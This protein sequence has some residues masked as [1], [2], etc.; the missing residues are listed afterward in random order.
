MSEARTIFRNTSF[1]AAS[2]VVERLATLALIFVVARALGAS[3]LGVYAAA[4]AFYGLFTVAGD[5]GASNLMVREIARDRSVAAKYL[6][7]LGAAGI[8]LAALATAGAWLVIP[9]VGLE[10]DL[11][12]G[13]LIVTLATIPG[14]LRI[15]QE[16]VFV[17]YQRLEFQAGVT[18]VVSL[19]TV[20][21]TITLI[22]LGYGV[23][24][25]IVAFVVVRWAMVFVYAALLQRFI[26]SLR[27]RWSFHTL[28]AQLVE[29]RAFAGLSLLGGLFARP[30]VI[31]L[32]A[33]VGTT[34]A[35]YYSAAMRV[36]LVWQIIPQTFMVNVFPVLSAAY[37]KKADEFKRIPEKAS[38][39]LLAITLPLAAGM[40][41]AAE[42]IV[43]LIYGSEFEPAVSVMR[44]LAIALP[45]FSVNSVL[46]RVLVARD[47]QG[48]VLGVFS[49][50]VVMR[51]TLAI[52]LAVAFG[53]LGA[54]VAATSVIVLYNLALAVLVRMAGVDL[55]VLPLIERFLPATVFM[56]VVGWL[57][58]PVL[59][60]W[61]LV[62]VTAAVYAVAVWL[63]RAFSADDIALFR[64]VLRTH[65][66]R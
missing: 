16:S 31:I 29:V 28:W 10:P 1:L 9:H 13:F 3:S 39:Y 24:S 60:L 11:E 12:T 61:F 57:L 32:A 7:H 38:K 5:F 35:G 20:A 58:V 66:A 56:A 53:A 2:R 64:S 37:K 46:W 18:F 15:L 59:A 19:I 62:P 23:T 30:E 26:V 34:Q 40:I 65:G 55:R 17:A 44:V 27:C 22:A 43:E 8:L 25:L 33:V 63:L 42:P 14:A 51:L 45:F 49:V 48:R 50:A 47:K 54:A 52:V 41:V 21:A 4:V 6:L 36:V